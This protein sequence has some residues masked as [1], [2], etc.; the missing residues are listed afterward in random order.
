MIIAE[1]Q[2]G[3]DVGGA[4]GEIGAIHI[5]EE[6]GDD[7]QRE[8]PPLPA[9]KSGAARRQHVG[10]EPFYP[11]PA[12]GTGF[13]WSQ[14]PEARYAAGEKPARRR[15]ARTDPWRST[16]RYREARSR[17]FPVRDTGR[18]PP[19]SESRNTSSGRRR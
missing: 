12:Q 18:I 7:Q 15:P 19:R 3:L 9:G 13:T 2:L 16:A 14:P 6:A 8:D 1:V 5:I 17:G 4:Y 11:G 10:H